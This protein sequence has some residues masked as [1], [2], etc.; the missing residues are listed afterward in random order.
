MDNEVKFRISIED[1]GT[2][3]MKTIGVNA[4]DL[5]EAIHEVNKEMDEL[6]PSVVNFAQLAQ[7]ID[8]VT[9]VVDQLNGAFKELTSM[10]KAQVEVDTKLATAMRNTMGATD[11]EIQS[12]KD[13]CS[14]QQDLGII[15]D[16]VQLAGAQ[17]LATYLEEKESL[18][19]LIPVLNDTTAQQYGFS[20][21]QE[22]SAQIATMFGKVMNGQVS[23]LSRYGYSF[24]EAQE[25]ILKFG[26]ES[27][28]AAVLADVVSQSVGGMN[29][30]LAQTDAGR[31]KQLEN[32][33]GDIK[34]QLG[35]LIQN[36][37]PYVSGL[38]A[39]AN[40][41][42]GI[43]KL[44]EAYS[45]LDVRQKA[46]AASG[47]ALAVH[48]KVQAIA[49]KLLEASGYSAAAGT[50][51]LTVATTA[52]YAALTMGISLAVAGLVSL[53]TSLGDEA[54]EAADKTLGL[55]QAQDAFTSTASNVKAELDMEVNKL[56]TLIKSNGDAKGAV[57]ELNKKYGEAFGYHKTAQEWYDTLIL[58][59]RAYCQQLGYEA[60]AKVIAA[61]K[62]AKELELEAAKSKVKAIEDSGNTTK[63]GSVTG[64]A[65]YTV[66]WQDETDEYRQAKADVAA[67]NSEVEELGRSWDVCTEKIKEATEEIGATVPGSSPSGSASGGS[68][69]KQ[70]GPTAEALIQASIAN[71]QALV[72][73]QIDGWNF[74]KVITLTAE[75]D[76]E[77]PEEEDPDVSA[78]DQLIER[79]QHRQQIY[80]QL[81]QSIEHLQSL[82]LYA[83]GEEVDA[84]N[85][86]IA[87][88]K[89]HQKALGK[90]DPEK[91]I[92]S[93]KKYQKLL[94]KV[95]EEH[96]QSIEAIETIGSTMGTL[97]Q[98]VGGAAGEWLTWGANLAQAIAAAIPKILAL[99]EAQGTQ[100]TAN[101]ATAATGAASSVA[102]IPYV[103]P[104]LAVAAVASV[105]A[106]LAS[107]P[108]FANGAI[109]YGPTLGI[110]GEYANAASNPEVVAPL[111]KLRDL[112]QPEYEVSSS[113]ARRNVK[114]RIRGR[115]LVGVMN[116]ENNLKKRR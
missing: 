84:I 115:D 79:L 11:E 63:G 110:F 57:D 41:V 34:E 42:G 114:F 98:A 1:S 40:A 91:S 21:T 35:G 5:R 6:K 87:A 101:A 71:M 50:T 55:R 26:T 72:Q 16:E 47:A 10:S 95:R 39:A 37:M 86:Q 49:Q 116:N 23:A 44:A 74:G 96:E 56:Q 54:D 36:L 99:V 66:H 89:E 102:S 90:S 8:A 30:A 48:Q 67:L 46:A 22:S 111:N 64:P 17:E 18:E 70:S 100:A 4:E 83:S 19:K 31:Q 112:I 108:K 27:E 97:G 85:A 13:L 58:K 109:A 93:Y 75:L 113:A 61:Q 25:K 69:S 76:I 92:S 33:L 81:A 14:A 65:G 38:S 24:D 28:R 107:L 103:G 106:S 62:A 78:Q 15:G 60:Q 2:S 77:P 12:I 32:T 43:I 105:L 88:M 59:S 9:G 45:T 53:F 3:T 7:G 20:A 94:Q 29:A 82:S 68:S 52:L 51:A 80:D 73:E 104:I